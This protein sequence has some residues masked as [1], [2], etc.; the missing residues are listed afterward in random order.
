VHESTRFLDLAFLSERRVR[1]STAQLVTGSRWQAPGFFESFVRLHGECASDPAASTV[2]ISVQTLQSL[3]GVGAGAATS[4][5]GRAVS[6]VELRCPL[7]RFL[8]AQHVRSQL[9]QQLRAESG[10]G[11]GVGWKVE[12]D[13]LTVPTMPLEFHLGDVVRCKLAVM[14]MATP[15]LVV[16]VGGTV[17]MAAS[18]SA[19]FGG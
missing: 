14:E 5:P 12:V 2:E 15:S 1:I 10:S 8:S 16:T 17:P 11:G 13:D 7:H 4:G 18:Q 6:A 19:V 3:C 9:Q